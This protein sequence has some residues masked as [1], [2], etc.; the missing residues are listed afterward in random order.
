VSVLLAAAVLWS[1][2][3]LLG[4]VAGLVV[5]LWPLLVPLAGVGM[6][7]GGLALLRTDGGER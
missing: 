6:V 3:N 1:G 7:V 5:V 4:L 2:V